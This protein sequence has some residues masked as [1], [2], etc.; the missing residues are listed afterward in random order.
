[1]PQGTSVPVAI[2]FGRALPDSAVAALLTRHSVRPYAVY[3]VAAGEGTSFRRDRSR[4]SLELLGEAREQAV[5]QLRTSLCA[6]PGRARALL[7]GEEPRGPER[8]RELLAQLAEL[9][10]SIPEIETGAPVV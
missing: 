10:R 8:E 1:L 6:Q 4:A 7:G 5:A 9:Q 2:G 3:L